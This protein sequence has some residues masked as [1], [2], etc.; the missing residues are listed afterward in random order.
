MHELPVTRGML[1]V[2]LDA[3]REEGAEKILAVDVVI[4]ELTSFV[5]DAVQFY[6]D[7]IAEDTL[8]EDARLRFRRE[9]ARV[10]CHDCGAVHRT[11]P[12]LRPTCPE[13]GSLALEVDG[14]RDFYV[15]SIEVET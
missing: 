9:Q 8:A 4:G 5:D 11:G 10:T 7:V 6:F 15:E 2:A 12:P 13:C 14:G 3:A 1:E